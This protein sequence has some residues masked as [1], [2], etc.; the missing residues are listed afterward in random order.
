MSSSN[1][2]TNVADSNSETLNYIQE[3][4]SLEQGIF[5]TLE[6]SGSSMTQAE[7][8]QLINQMND[9][10]QMR[11][12]LYQSLSGMNSLFQNALTS[13]RDTLDEQIV[14]IQI[15]EKQL[16][17]AKTRLKSL[18]DEKNNNIRHI[19]INDY[20]AERYGQHAQLMKVIIFMLV[21]IIILAVLY[22]KGILPRPIYLGLIVIVGAIG[23]YFIWTTYF[24][25]I[26]RDN[27][28]YQQYDWSF[29]KK[30]APSNTGTSTITDPWSGGASDLCVGPQCC[31]TYEMFDASLNQCTVLSRNTTQQ[32]PNSTSGTNLNAA[33]SSGLNNA[34]SNI[35]SGIS[36]L[37][38]G[39]S[40][41][42]GS[43]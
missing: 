42:F 38:S 34:S 17:Q 22:N 23:F 39:L 1:T 7:Q 8:N 2:L 3:L 25:M 14:A 21:P 33:I 4:Q 43:M 32:A 13:S 15:V 30:T 31:T 16:N 37:T 19:E 36:S 35:S 26:R 41:S 20:Y 12:N 18:E 24:S 40:N 11:I 27:M 28:N 29:N 5:T 9:I 10:S 6:Q